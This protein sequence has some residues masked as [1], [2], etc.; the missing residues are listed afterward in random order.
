MY[1][2]E[3]VMSGT[4]QEDDKGYWYISIRLGFL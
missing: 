2:S 3:Q 4:E 1:I